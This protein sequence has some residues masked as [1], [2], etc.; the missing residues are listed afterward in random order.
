ML[1]IALVCLL[2]FDAARLVVSLLRKRALAHK[3]LLKMAAALQSWGL[4]TIPDIL[5][6]IATGDWIQVDKD[7]EFWV[8]LFEGNPDAAIAELDKVVVHVAQSS[9]FSTLDPASLALVKAAVDAAVAA[10]APKA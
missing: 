1:V 5:T 3:G 2:C 8:R 6:S 4:V 9:A 10:A 7:V